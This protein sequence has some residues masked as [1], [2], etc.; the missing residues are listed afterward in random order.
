MQLPA[1]PP[2]ASAPPNEPLSPT[3]WDRRPPVVSACP[4][5]DFFWMGGGEVDLKMAVRAADFIRIY[6]PHVAD[7]TS[8][9]QATGSTVG[10]GLE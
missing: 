1:L 2:A 3:P 6:R 7:V 9:D 5:P 10:L 8:A 4:Q